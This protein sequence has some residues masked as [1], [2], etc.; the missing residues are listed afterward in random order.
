[1]K[2]KFW[3][4]KRGPVYYLLNAESGQRTSLQTTDCSTAEKIIRA[5][6][7][8]AQSPALGLALAKAYLSA[9]DPKLA[10]RTWQDVLNEFCSR[11]QPQTQA[12]R[13]RRVRHRA[14]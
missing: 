7:E 10:K 4:C 8:A 1:M 13:K 2:K 9:H 14:L 12:L 3:L 5:R 11:G 6:N